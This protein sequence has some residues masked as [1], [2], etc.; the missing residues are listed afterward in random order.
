VAVLQETPDPADK[1]ELLAGWLNVCEAM[2]PVREELRAQMEL[3]GFFTDDEDGTPPKLP[4][5]VYRAAWEDDEAEL[6][7]SWT[8]ERSVAEFFCRHHTSLRAMFLGL[9][10]DDVDMYILEATC[11]EMYG[12]ITG[13]SESE[14]IAKTLTDVEPIAALQREAK[15]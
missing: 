2:A 6:A 10:R 14:V 15:A 8:T 12:W 9:Y 5:T 7:L 4:V 3:A 1:R 11:T 13:R